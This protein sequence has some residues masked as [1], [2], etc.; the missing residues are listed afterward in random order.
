MVKQPPSDDVGDRDLRVAPPERAAA[1][2]T[3]VTAALSASLAQMGVRRTALTLLKVNQDGGFDCPGCAW[4]EPA[5]GRRAHA[6]FCENGAKA[7]AEEATLRRVTPEFFA[8]H[9]IC[10][11][12]GRSDH[13]LGQ[14]GRLTVPVL[15]RPGAEHYT[16]VSWDDAFALI[17][18]ELRACASPD[19][20]VFYTSG[21]TSN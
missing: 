9:R 19:E 8:A 6:E 2:A 20:A 16:P 15:R 17:A 21:R 13:W 5:P 11:L 1:G 4:P 18:A 3:A 7:V 10:E 12:A 14:Q